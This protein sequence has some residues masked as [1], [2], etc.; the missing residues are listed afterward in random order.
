[1]YDT[2]VSTSDYRYKQSGC[3][4]QNHFWEADS[5]SASQEIFH[6]LWNPKVHHRIHNSPLFVPVL[7]PINPVHYVLLYTLKMQC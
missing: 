6:I 3:K 7:S 2:V 5:S 1:M 4:Y